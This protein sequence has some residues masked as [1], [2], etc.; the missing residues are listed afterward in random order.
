MDDFRVPR[1]EED[2]KIFQIKYQTWDYADL[3]SVH[4]NKLKESSLLDD[5]TDTHLIPS[6]EVLMWNHFAKFFKGCDNYD[7]MVKKEANK[8]L[9]LSLE[10]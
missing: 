3:H 9:N 6:Q 10:N 5:G 7:D 8:L 2:K 1:E 4:R